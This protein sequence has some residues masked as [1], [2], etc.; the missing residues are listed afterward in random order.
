MQTMTGTPL[1]FGKE[2]LPILWN[3][4]W[5]EG[6]MP[7]AWIHLHELWEEESPAKRMPHE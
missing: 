3:P 5:T 2:Q 4:S 7:G 1:T 6:K